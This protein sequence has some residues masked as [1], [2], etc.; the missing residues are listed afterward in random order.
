MGKIGKNIEKSS[1]DPSRQVVI[2]TTEKDHQLTMGRKTY[3]N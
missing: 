1:V 3:K 2:Q